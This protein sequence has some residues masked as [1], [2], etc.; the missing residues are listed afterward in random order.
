L[1]PVDVLRKAKALIEER[2]WCKGRFVE[3]DG[4]C[5]VEGAV[6]LASGYPEAKLSPTRPPQER[7]EP[8]L[9][10]AKMAEARILS[11]AVGRAS[12]VI[13]AWNDRQGQT[14][15][16]ILAGIDRAIALAEQEASS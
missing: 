7:E 14:K 16:D 8:Y 9:R 15:Q 6:L 1:S 11:R 2:G 12:D 3:D 10:F 4:S 13:W 5:C